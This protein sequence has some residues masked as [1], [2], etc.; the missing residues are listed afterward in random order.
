MSP[1]RRQFWQPRRRIDVDCRH[2]L[3]AGRHDE[4]AMWE[5]CCLLDLAR[6]GETLAWEIE[7]QTAP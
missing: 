6:L 4:T 5:W 7:A 2:S 1:R 3:K